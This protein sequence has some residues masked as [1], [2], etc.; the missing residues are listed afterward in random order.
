[1]MSASSSGVWLPSCNMPLSIATAGSAVVLARLT[2]RG[3]AL[4]NRDLPE[5][6]AKGI[7]DRL[8]FGLVTQLRSVPI[9]LRVDA[10]LMENYPEIRCGQMRS[11]IDEIR[12]LTTALDPRAATTACHR[13][14]AT[15]NRAAPR[16]TRR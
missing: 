3:G 6:E 4:F 5:A 10:W 15:P 16:R 14:R 2:E 11:I 8:R 12:N 9:G 1:M 7:A 13:L